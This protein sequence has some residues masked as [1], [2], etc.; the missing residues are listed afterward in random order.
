MQLSRF[1]SDVLSAFRI[2]TWLEAGRLIGLQEHVIW[3]WNDTS[4]EF[5][6]ILALKY[7]DNISLL[8]DSNGNSLLLHAAV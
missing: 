5:H 2:V 4:P 1:V 7:K 6:N 8:Q 3:Y